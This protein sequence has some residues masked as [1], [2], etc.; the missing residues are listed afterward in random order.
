VYLLRLT[1]LGAFSYFMGNALLVG[2]IRALVSLSNETSEKGF[3]VME[4]RM[5]KE[6]HCGGCDE[7]K[8][9]SEFSKCRSKKDGLQSRCKKCRR[10]LAS[11]YRQ[12]AAGKQTEQRYWRSD[13]HKASCRRYMKSSLGKASARRY[14]ARGVVRY[15]EKYK[16][17]SAVRRAVMT[18]RLP[19]ILTQDCEHCDDSADH[20]HHPDYNYPLDVIALCRQCHEDEHKQ[21]EV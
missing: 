8:S 6:K 5:S 10:E 17:R 9:V 20:Y 19:N 14:Y 13:R 15:P 7:T 1:E 2:A 18:G 11:N 21:G 12:S 4:E 3:C 16:A